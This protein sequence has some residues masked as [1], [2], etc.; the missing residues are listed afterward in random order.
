MKTWGGEERRLRPVPCPRPYI[1]LPFLH[2]TPFSFHAA[3]TSLVVFCLV[4]LC[5]MRTRL[6]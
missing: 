5:F 4:C 1:P 3:A 6:M 2:A